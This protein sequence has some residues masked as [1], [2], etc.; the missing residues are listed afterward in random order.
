MYK[1]TLQQNIE[2]NAPKK[3]LIRLR[4]KSLHQKNR[5]NQ[6]WKALQR[7]CIGIISNK[8]ATRFTTEPTLQGFD[9]KD[10]ATWTTDDLHKKIGEL[11]LASLLDK[12]LLQ[13]TKLEPF[14]AIIIKGNVRYLR[15]TLYDLLAHRALDYFKSDEQ[16]ITRPAYAFEI[17]EREAFAPANEF[18][19]HKFITNDTSSLH[20]K[21]LSIFKDILIF[22]L[23]DAKPDALI[24]ADIERIEFVHQYGVM[25]DKDTLYREAL[26]NVAEKYKDNPASAQ[27]AF[28]AAQMIYNN[29]SQSSKNA[30]KV[31]SYTVKQAKGMLDV[32]AKKFPDSEGGINSRNLI[33]QIIH[34]QLNL[35]TEKVN[36][37][38]LPFRTLVSYKNFN[39][40]YFR[41]LPLTEE[42]KARLQGMD[43]DKLFQKLVSEKSIR[44]WQQ[45]LPSTSDYL[46]HSAEVKI[47]ALPVGEYVLL[48][49]ASPDFS[50]NKNPLA[51][52][53]FYV[54]NISFINS[55]QQYF[56]LDRTTGQP[57]KG[58]TVQVYTQNYNY[59]TRT[60]KLQQKELLKA[61]EHGYFN[62]A[63]PKKNENSSVRLDITYQKDR[64]FLDDLQYTYNYDS[65]N[66]NDDYDDQEDYDEDNAK[67]FLFTDR[68]IYRPGQTVYFK[69]IG[70]TQN[71]KTKKPA[72]LQ[73]KDSLIVYLYD[74]NS[75]RGDSLKLVL[76]DFGSFNG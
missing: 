36:V 14:D 45:D 17:K 61:D 10:I 25:D 70:I 30:A 53:Y 5:Q 48:G 33:N 49:S 18:I 12:N 28:L 64:L 11:Y 51:A 66:D 20:Q 16:D 31:S 46:S 59:N 15:P 50:L 72:L 55:G 7:R 40:L 62:L 57:L 43:N 8:T 24:D 44:E 2:E 76:N 3:A 71:W 75:Q 54:S 65:N 37:P 47:N 35:T 74:V 19:Q 32:I 22:H 38:E 41:I 1:I 27:A 58:A 67:V 23:N 73:S 9:K 69:G 52:E 29:A 39:I 26:Q 21:A 42:S 6:S 60:Y 56:V 68:S 13:Q 63:A 4:K 34:P